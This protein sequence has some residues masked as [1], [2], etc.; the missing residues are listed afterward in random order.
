MKYM[1]S[2]SR[3][4]AEILSI[5]LTNRHPSQWYIEPFCGGCNIIDKVS[6]SRLANDIHPH[7]MAMWKALIDGWIPEKITKEFYL[8]VRS[9]KEKYPAHIVGWVGFNCSYSGKYF[10]GFAG[11]T[12]T[13]I[14]ITRDYQKEAINNV[15]KQIKNLE[16]VVFE[17]K[18][19]CD[20][21]LNKNSIIYCD[22]P[23]EGTAKYTEHAGTAKYIGEFHHTTF[24]EWV[25]EVSKKHTVYVSEYNAP[26]D[27]ECIW[28]KPTKT[29]MSANGIIGSGST[30]SV[31]KLFKFNDKQTSKQPILTLF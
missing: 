5:I 26:E 28:S 17:N 15:L 3:F 11:E 24:W 25:R 8:E 2:K 31:E 10:R 16:G 20:L 14:G 30:N 1:G 7:L 21:V 18:S 4:A 9:N 23:Y 27:F 13:K 22:P 29:S 6:G 12:G 19:Y